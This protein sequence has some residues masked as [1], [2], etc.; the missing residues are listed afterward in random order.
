MRMSQDL[1]MTPVA[2]RRLSNHRILRPSASILGGPSLSADA[3]LH[4]LKTG[5]IFVF[6]RE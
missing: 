5:P 1:G 4:C 3:L 6:A 2:E